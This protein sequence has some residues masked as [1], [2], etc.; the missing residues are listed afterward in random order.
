[1][2]ALDDERTDDTTADADAT[3][4]DAVV[5]VLDTT[6]ARYNRAIRHAIETVEGAGR[7]SLAQ[8]RCLQ[9]M[10]AH[11][12]GSLTSQLARTLKVA[13]PTM[14]SMIDGLVERGLVERQPHPTDRRQVRL[15]VTED[16][17]HTLVR[18][19][20]IVHDR[21]AAPLARLTPD[22]KTR[23]IDAL[24]DLNTLLDDE[25]PRETREPR[26]TDG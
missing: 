16:G 10:G 20:R 4:D 9:V 17:R 26:S 7:L 8:L 12:D 13:V 14:T 5:S 18:Y 25:P 22:Q 6:A 21:I 11:A 24:R 3:D 2:L 19:H 1:M 15:L 23:L